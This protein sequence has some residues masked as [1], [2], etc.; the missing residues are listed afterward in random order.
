[1]AIFAPFLREGP[2]SSR[3]LRAGI[4]LLSGW[5]LLEFALLHLIAARI[6]WGATLIGLSLKGGLG[7]VFL[8]YCTFRGLRRV[9][10]AETGAMRPEISAGFGVAS[11]VLVALP[12]ILPALLGLALLSPSLQMGVLRFLRRDAPSD[13]PRE[14]ELPKSEWRE[15]ARRKR[16]LPA[17]KRGARLEA[18][19]P[20]V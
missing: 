8:G 18:G 13:H 17:G 10:K 7:L 6:G 3:F 2:L 19:P 20:S 9:V 1:M 5:A 16:R 15:T 12:G 14:I 11:A 4:V